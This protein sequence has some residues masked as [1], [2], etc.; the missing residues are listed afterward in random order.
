MYTRV[1]YAALRQQDF[2]TLL[3]EQIAKI[4]NFETQC[5]LLV[6]LKLLRGGWFFLINTNKK[7]FF[8]NKQKI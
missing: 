8:L 1:R 4:S 5:Q 3:I 6:V 7:K 2:E